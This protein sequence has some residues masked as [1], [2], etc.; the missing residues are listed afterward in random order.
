MALLKTRKDKKKLTFA[1]DEKDDRTQKT[2]NLYSY[3]FTII[4]VYIF[5]ITVYEIYDKNGNVPV[6][7]AWFLAYSTIAVTSF[8]SSL[9]TLI[10]D[11]K[12]S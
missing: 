2:A 7:F 5:S 1:Y 6:M 4:Y 8:I 12:S 3:I 10:T 9:L 11:I